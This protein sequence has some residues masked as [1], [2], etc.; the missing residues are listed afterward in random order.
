MLEYDVVD[1]FTDRP[2]AGNQLA[3]VHGAGHLD[4]AQCLAVAREF[5]LSETTFPEPLGPDAYRVRI[6]TPGGEVPFA[7]HPTLG[8]A[9][10]LRDRGTLTGPAAV[11]HCAAGPI[12]VGFGADAVE[13]AAVPREPATPVDDA[14]EVPLLRAL[15]LGP[16]D[17]AGTAY[18]AG[19]G[20]TFLQV[21]VTTDAV[22]RAVPLGAGTAATL[23]GPVA[24][25]D[26]LGGVE[27]YAVTVP[28]GPERHVEVHARVFVPEY[29]VPEDPATGSAATA[30][31]L[32]LVAAGVLPDGGTYRIRQGAE[33][34]R[35]SVLHGAVDLDPPRCRV[36]GAVR[37]VA[38]GR[39][40]EPPRS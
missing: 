17:L 11:Q 26:P 5:N 14:V 22:A 4:T 7:G 32:T 28:D 20:L 25:R 33:L 3:V 38:R 37:P 36:S 27:L 40:V 16:G 12:G 21:P 39:I 10:V 18:V 1:V 13:L 31:G 2:Y 34:G 6:F 15:G 9:W 35:P 8:T 30:L 19:T 23:L 24:T 29:A